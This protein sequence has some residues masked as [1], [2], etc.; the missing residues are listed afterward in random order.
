[1]NS[2]PNQNL[3]PKCSL[4]K[5]SSAQLLIKPI[6]E[7]IKCFHRCFVLSLFFSLFV[8][9]FMFDTINDKQGK[10]KKM[11]LR[12]ASSLAD[13]YVELEVAGTPILDW[14]YIVCLNYCFPTCSI[15]KLVLFSFPT[16]YFNA[17]CYVFFSSTLINIHQFRWSVID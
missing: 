5:F 15:I 10:K 7:M 4:C 13:T 2:S 17:N 11:I 9:T 14:L 6:L 1:M 12:I 3:V 8:L 16:Y